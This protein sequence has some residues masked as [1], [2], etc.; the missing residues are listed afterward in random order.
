M[1]RGLPLAGHLPW[2]WADT[3]GF[4]LRLARSQ[5]DVAV[6]RL[7]RKDAYLLSH[8]DHVQRVLV[9]DADLF[10]KGRL[11][12]RARRL[13]GDGLLTS[14]G[15]TH[16]VQRRRLQPAFCR[17][18]LLR[19]GESVPEAAV[20]ATATWAHATVVDVGA[21]MDRLAMAVIARTLLGADLDGAEAPLAA[22]LRL[23]ARRAPLFA[24]PFAPYLERA[25]LP[26]FRAAGGAVTRLEASVLRWIGSPS[27]AEHRDF[28]SLLRTLP[29]HLA[30]DEAMTIFLAGHD[31]T[32]AALTWTWYL[33][34]THP[35]VARRVETEVDDVLGDRD[36]GPADLPAL[37]YIGMVFDE[38]LRLYP[39]VGRI[40]RRPVADCRID[41]HDLPEGAPVFLSPYVTQR[42]PRWWPKPDRFDPERWAA[43]AVASRPRYAAFPFGAG[44]RSCIGGQMARVV[45]QLVIATLARRWRMSPVPGPAPRVRGVLTLKPVRPIRLLLQRRAPC[46]AERV[47]AGGPQSAGC[48]ITTYPGSSA[49][50]ATGSTRDAAKISHTATNS[51]AITGPITN[52]LAPNTA[53]PPSVEISTT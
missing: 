48:G 53:M 5:G 23:I 34:A 51:A 7:G 9:D 52:P 10:R 39:A 13:L 45:G 14:E 47:P 46:D 28:L 8:P 41:G 32:A 43:G 3:T 1:R 27:A 24:V 44:P 15:E 11:M 30:R 40:G 12:H 49:G 31:T 38:A 4:L 50:G 29:P 25:G 42:D 20:G 35:H 6:F 2:F 22:D 26:P 36:P 18:Q 17:H 33:L 16:R 21:A 19:Y 37:G